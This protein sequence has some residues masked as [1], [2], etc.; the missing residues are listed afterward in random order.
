MELGVG[1]CINMFLLDCCVGACNC[2]QLVHMFLFAILNLTVTPTLFWWVKLLAW[3]FLS[4]FLKKEQLEEG[5]NTVEKWTED[6]KER[7]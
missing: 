2:Y 5:I 4:F 6:G 7:N 1:T 3:F